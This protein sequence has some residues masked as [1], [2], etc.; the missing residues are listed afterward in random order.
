MKTSHLRSVS[1]AL[2]FA[3]G[4][5]AACWTTSAFGQATPSATSLPRTADGH[6]DFT[7]AWAMRP[8]MVR[9]PDPRGICVGFNCGPAAPAA[10][11]NATPVVRPAPNFPKYKAEFKA[12]VDQFNKAQVKFDPALRCGNPGIPRI[13]PPDKIVQTKTD[14][15]MLYDDL[16]GAFWRIIPFSKAHKEDAEESAMG[17]SIARWDGDKLVIETTTF[18]DDTWLT[19]NGTFHTFNMKVVE[20]LSPSGK[21]FEYKLTVN[22]PEV[23]A[24]PWVKSA[25]LNASADPRQPVPCVEKSIDKMAGIESYHPNARW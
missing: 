22:D 17:D 8:A 5:S 25:K 4:A 11:P 7:G 23:L 24:E 9:P 16:N 13:G 3:V 21:S 15:V 1:L 19:D 6:P 18:N 12:K 10:D 20:E 14:V 2:M